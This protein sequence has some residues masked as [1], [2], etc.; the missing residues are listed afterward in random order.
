MMRNHP[1]TAVV[2]DD[3]HGSDGTLAVH[4]VD[5]C[6][7]RFTSVGILLKSDEV[8]VSIA[9]ELGQDGKFRDITFIPRAMIVE[10]YSLGNLRKR[11]RRGSNV[12]AV[13]GT[14][15]KPAQRDG[16]REGLQRDG[17]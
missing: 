9:A 1:L 10:E 4:E 7:Y 14:R 15:A 11:G 16:G 2:W 13:H 5:H 6:P 12:S 8:G 17:A 3:A